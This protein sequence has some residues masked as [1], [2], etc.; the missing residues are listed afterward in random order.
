MIIVYYDSA[1]Q[2]AFE[3]IVRNIGTARNNI[4]KG[5]MASAMKKMTAAVDDMDSDPDAVDT[6]RTKLGTYTKTTKVK[7]GEEKTVYDHIDT[8]LD[9]SQAQCERAA[10]QFLRDGDCAEEILSIRNKMQELNELASGE[11]QRIRLQEER[12][13]QVKARKLLDPTRT[14]EQTVV[15]EPKPKPKDN[16]KIQVQVQAPTRHDTRGAMAARIAAMN[17]EFDDSD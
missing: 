15:A 14:T 12:A 7:A 4:R 3:M 6:L 13:E 2:E 11:L 17:A 16:D 9:F 8:G 1:V 5:K 10:H